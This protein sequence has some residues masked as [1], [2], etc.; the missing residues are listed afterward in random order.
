MKFKTNEVLQKD[1]TIIVEKAGYFYNGTH[2]PKWLAGYSCTKLITYPDSV[3]V[4]I[5]Q[6]KY[7]R[8][9]SDMKVSKYFLVED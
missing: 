4:R 9:C 8:I 6:R 1:K 2:L 5:R 7:P 3:L